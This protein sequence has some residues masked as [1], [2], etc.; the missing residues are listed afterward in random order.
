M[1]SRENYADVLMNSAQGRIIVS[2]GD[3]PYLYEIVGPIY[4]QVS[5]RGLFG[6][7]YGRLEKKYRDY[8]R[9]QRTDTNEYRGRGIDDLVLLTV[10]EWSMNG[11]QF[12]K[13][14][15]MGVEEMK[16][17]AAKLRAD[18]IIHLRQDVDLDTNGFQY[19]YLQMY[20]TAVRILGPR[21]ES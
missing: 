2:T 9:Q 18:A 17:S 21:P 20:G 15:Y 6:S 4:F 14:F 5:N 1:S 7:K 10:G 19:F 11:T 13:A 3:I 16:A 12:E 8:F